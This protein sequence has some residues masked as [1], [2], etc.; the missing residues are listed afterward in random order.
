M[1]V[2]ALPGPASRAEPS[3]TE[4]VESGIRAAT[5]RSGASRLY[6]I[7]RGPVRPHVPGDPVRQHHRQ[8]LHLV[9]AVV[10]QAR[11]VSRP[12]CHRPV[13]RARG[14]RA[15]DG[16]LRCAGGRRADQGPE[17]RSQVSRRRARS[18]G[19]LLSQN[20]DTEIRDYV[21]R[22]PSEIGKTVSVWVL[23]HGQRRRGD[24]ECVRPHSPGGAAQAVRPAA[25]LDR[26]GR[27]R[28]HPAAALQYRSLHVRR[29]QPAGNGRRRRGADRLVL[30]DD[31]RAAAGGAARRRW[32]PSISRSSRRRTG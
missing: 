19:Q 30:H 3:S 21:L 8:G 11:R 18:R 7:A 22:N 4:I 24:E 32:P 12:G 2:T 10:V 9:P 13:G 27:G 28:G 6:G 17:A 16:R 25:R 29:I 5:R 1:A 20:A 14:K 26:P 31:D 23:A 15:P